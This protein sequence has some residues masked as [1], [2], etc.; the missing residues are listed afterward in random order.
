M[1]ARIKQFHKES[2]KVELLKMFDHVILFLY[3]SNIST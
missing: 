3:F 2:E 1:T